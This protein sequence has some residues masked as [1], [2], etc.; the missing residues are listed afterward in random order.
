MRRTRRNRASLGMI[1]LGVDI[2]GQIT[3]YKALGL[4]DKSV[5]ARQVVD[6]SFIK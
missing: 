1:R 4:I 2:G 5:D 3:R 6:A